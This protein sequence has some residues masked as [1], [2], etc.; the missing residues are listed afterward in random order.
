MTAENINTLTTD[1]ANL[2]AT[3][4]SYIITFDM[5]MANE[6]GI[7]MYY[8]G[9]LIGLG[10]AFDETQLEVIV[11]LISLEINCLS[12]QLTEESEGTTAEDLEKAKTEMLN[13]YELVKTGYESFTDE[14][15]TLFDSYF[16]GMYQLYTQYCAQFVTAQ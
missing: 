11:N 1:F 3:T 14:V 8:N 6:D 7:I 4:K 12:Y 10:D 15:K 16:S 2:S 13:T 5:S 9:I